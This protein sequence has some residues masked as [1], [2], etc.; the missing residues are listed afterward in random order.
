MRNFV[1]W[2]TAALVIFLFWQVSGRIQKNERYLSFSDFV[3]QVER[4]HVD[5]VTF[6]G[7]SISGA[8]KNGQ[9]FRTFAPSQAEGLVDALLEKGVVVDARDVGG[10]SWEAHLVSWAPIV[11]VI[12]FLIFFGRFAQGTPDL[13]TMSR[14]W[15]ALAASDEDLSLDEL[16]AKL[17]FRSKTALKM[18]LFQ[19]IREK[20]VVFSSRKKY[21]V[22]RAE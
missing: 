21:R 2:L 11:I 22:A 3:A 19:M 20:T 4:G 8:F 15:E 5:N 16:S 10:A 14:I 1:V 12:A 13:A 7:N 17:S 6:T 9:A 18:A